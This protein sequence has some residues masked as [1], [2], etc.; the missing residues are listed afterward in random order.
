MPI[1]MITFRGKT[2]SMSE[3]ARELGISRER[4]RQRLAKGPVEYALD[5][6]RLPPPKPGFHQ[7]EKTLTYRGETRTISEWAQCLGISAATLYLRCRKY[8]TVAALS[9]PRYAR[10][11]RAKKKKKE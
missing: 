8:G 11:Q 1:R 7:E 9:R 10:G 4:V 5:L 2:Q 3:W 6:S